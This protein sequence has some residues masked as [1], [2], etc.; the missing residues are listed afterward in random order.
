MRL[1]LRFSSSQL[2]TFMRVQKRSDAHFKE[3]Y[4]LSSRKLHRFNAIALS[5]HT[6]HTILS[7][8][9]VGYDCRSMQFSI[10]CG[11][12]SIISGQSIEPALE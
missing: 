2:E 11:T 12:I 4:L 1:I 6:V 8:G 9:L 10:R 5:A 7:I 3:S